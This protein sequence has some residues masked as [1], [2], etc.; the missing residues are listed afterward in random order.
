MFFHV[1]YA[2]QLY[3]VVCT[4][5]DG[6]ESHIVES[7]LSKSSEGSVFSESGERGQD[8]ENSLQIF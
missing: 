4:V 8:D 1:S 5:H 6:Y 7:T 2:R 3:C